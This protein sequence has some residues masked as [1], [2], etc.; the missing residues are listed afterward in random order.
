M[1]IGQADKLFAELGIAGVSDCIG[2]W[3]WVIKVNGGAAT[4]RHNNHDKA[5]M[6]KRIHPV[7]WSLGRAKNQEPKILRH[8][9]ISAT[10]PLPGSGLRRD[11][12][13]AKRTWERRP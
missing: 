2:R 10:P 12:D 6:A 7:L 1:L 5:V 8:S 9:P 3:F 4:Q 11:M 13:K